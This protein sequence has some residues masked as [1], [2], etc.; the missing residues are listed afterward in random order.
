MLPSIVAKE[1]QESV[2]DYMQLAFP[3]AT[4]F[5]QQLTAGS[6]VGPTALINELLHRDGAVFKGPYVDIKLPFRR[7]E[8]AKL[9]F[10]QMTLSYTPYVHQLKSFKRLCA[11]K[12]ASTIVATGTGSGKT[13]CFMLPV[14]DDALERR[15]PGIKTII[16][17]PMNALATDQARRFADEISKLDTQLTVG[18]FVGGDDDNVAHQ[19]MGPDHVITCKKTLR[20]NPPDILLTNY[21]MLD[22]LMI[23]PVDRPIWRYN[24]PG[25]LKYLVVD[26]LHSFDG[27]QGTDLACLIRRLRERL[28]CGDNLACVGT[29]ATMGTDSEDQLLNYASQ[30]F[31]TDFTQDGVIGE[32]RLTAKEY[33][34]HPPEFFDVPPTGSKGLNAENFSSLDDYLTEQVNLWFP[35]IPDGLF[36]PDFY[37]ETAAERAQAFVMLGKL[38][39][40]HAAFQQFIKATAKLRSF[41]ELSHDWKASGDDD[42]K[43][44]LII[45]M[46]ALTS[47]ARQWRGETEPN[48]EA[49]QTTNT[50]KLLEQLL[51]VRYQLWLREYR[52][53]VCRVP[54][55]KDHALGLE[56]SDDLQDQS[57]PLHLPLLHCRECHLAAWG[58]VSEAGEAHLKAGTQEFYERWFT[59]SPESTLLVPLT[60]EDDVSSQVEKICPHCTR[61]HPTSVKGGC[62]HCEHETLIPVWRPSIIKE[63]TKDGDAVHRC[64]HDCPDCGA[65]DSMMIVGA[66]AP[67]LTS[68]M[69]GRLFNS[70]YNDDY[71]LIAFSDSV[72]DAAHRAGFLGA[73]TWRT[74]V[75]QALAAFISK[76]DSPISLKTVVDNFA[77]YWREKI[78]NDAHFCGLFI[79][80]N[81]EWL[82]DYSHLKERGRLP[83]DSDLPYLVSRRMTWEAL[84]EFGLR[85]GIGRTLERT[86]F[87]AVTA[88]SSLQAAVNDLVPQLREEFESLRH[89]SETELLT[90]TLGWLTHL[91]SFG[92]ISHED[93]E[94][95]LTQGNQF[96]FAKKGIRA[97]LMPAF[98]YSTAYPK[99]ISIKH[100]NNAFESLVKSNYRT[101]SQGWLEKTIGQDNAFISAEAKSFFKRLCHVL[102]KHDWLKE[103]ECKGE[104]VWVLNADKLFISRNATYLECNKCRHKVTIDSADVDSINGS[105]CLRLKC[106]GTIGTATTSRAEKTVNYDNHQPR[107][108]A[109]HEHTGLLQRKDREQVEQS[110]IYGKEPWDV[111]LLSATPTLEMGIDIGALSTVFL[112]SVPPSQANYL[113][114]IGRAGRRDGN[115]M[116]ITLTGGQN[117]DRYFYSDPLKMMAGSVQTPGVFLKAI[118]VL[119]RQLIAY[120]FDRWVLTEASDT[121]IPGQLKKVI[122]AV[123][124]R[125]IADFPYNLIKFV[126]EHKTALLSGFYAMFPALESDERH[127]LDEFVSEQGEGTLSWRLINRLQ[128]LA[129]ERKLLAKRVEQL[130][131]ELDRL[132]KL[133]SDDETQNQIKAVT[134]ER[135]ALMSLQSSLNKQNTLNFFTDEGLLPNY[136]FPEEGVTLRSV[137]IKRKIVDSDDDEKPYEKLSYSFQRPSQTAISELAP[138]SHFY[139]VNHEIEVEQ[140]DLQLSETETW[141]FC[142]RCQYTERVDAGDRHSAC[143]RCGAPQWADAAQKQE[144]LKLRQVYATVDDRDNRID[145]GSETREPKFYNTQKLVDI[146][147]EQ[148]QGGFRLTSEELPFGFEYLK[149]ISLREVNFGPSGGN[150]NRIAV[151]GNETSRQGFKVCKHCG[152]VQKEHWKFNEQPHAFSCKL[153]KYPELDK[154]TEYLQSL[155]LY[156]ELKSEAV[157]IL[158]PLSEVAYSDEKLHSFIAAL[159]L[160]LKTYF[161]GS[162]DHLE[163]TDM[164]EPGGADSG[165]RVY[166]VVYDKIPGGTGYLKELMRSPDNLMTMLQSAYDVLKQCSCIDDNELDGCYECILAYRSSRNMPKISRATAA[167]LL[168]DI[169]QYRK[170]I[171]PIDKLSQIS[172]NTLIESKLEQ[173]FVDSLARLPGASLSKTVINGKSGH[174]LTLPDENDRPMPWYVEHQVNLGPKQ[175]VQIPT[176]AD[177]VLYPAR[178]EDRQKVKPVVVYLDGLQYHHEIVDDD[179]AKRASILASKNYW[180]FSLNWDDLPEPGEFATV[181]SKDLMSTPGK[182]EGHLSQL[183]DQVATQGWLKSSELGR[184]HRFTSMQWLYQF[185][186]LPEQTLGLL[187]QRAAYRA[188]SMLAPQAMKDASLR[189]A[190]VAEVEGYLTETLKQSIGIDDNNEIPGGICEALD[191]SLGKHRLISTVPSRFINQANVEILTTEANLHLFFDDSNTAMSDD[192]KACW[193][194]FWHA[195]N[196]LQFADGFTMTSLTMNK[197]GRSEAIYQ[198][199][200]PEVNSDSDVTVDEVRWPDVRDLSALATEQIDAIE[201]LELPEPEVGVDVLDDQ[202]VVILDGADLDLCWANAKVAVCFEPINS[203]EGWTLCED[204]DNLISNL[205]KLKQQ[206]VFDE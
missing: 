91:R 177:V 56:F 37:A 134:Q 81:K 206:G 13:E 5:F 93:M 130:K 12:P 132:K 23:R 160:G 171:E 86:A 139:A 40:R 38:L 87:S 41:D 113:Q 181:P 143:P 98:G 109:P 73:R 131:R 16:I 116:A 62:V 129:E 82:K 178:A 123:E 26:E 94:V 48:N 158:L 168:H 173:R 125:N 79:E 138:L 35:T 182:Y 112:L 165:E 77:N 71:K 103:Y 153:R 200:R 203:K 32:D 151:A 174:Q 147:P 34:T 1:M 115:A 8:G 28:E 21:K 128:K 105:P 110:F 43:R 192:F 164:T 92:A 185:L 196:Q 51:Q 161:K 75:R 58:A 67:T 189:E 55:G 42:Y 144:V 198:Q 72:Q 69:T 199:G 101:W 194:A 176:C 193:R 76:Q 179:I 60:H 156:R 191:N 68:V 148:M 66:R 167:E 64:H 53:L 80:P 155:F 142:S 119:E 166:L 201:S 145:D 141:R 122:D 30:V 187:Q 24:K 152:K 102:T 85:S 22:F 170:Q 90:F 18:L 133:P 50:E 157:R 135:V 44:L 169:L 36:R 137:I 99:G 63:S 188:M 59:K 118:A 31:A 159:N 100:L 104:S 84:L 57:K 9:P 96:L 20:K 49:L 74:T 180:V 29:S 163:V 186:R 205:E 88:D 3:I 19:T 2:A 45:S 4:P 146:P 183:Y 107:K 190:I 17:Y 114:R 197:V 54:D 11:D 202:G 121:A 7:A 126:T 65:R 111:N 14:L 27:A 162:V 175:G 195:A 204:D 106:K 127:Y 149:S 140:I 95:L 136:A 154:D 108:L 117:H 120:S 61:M 25:V 52:R 15:M 10:K 78:N 184:Y 124:S 39:H 172:T 70:T 33:L 89:L 46:A 97:R 83:K 6:E 47:A 150:R